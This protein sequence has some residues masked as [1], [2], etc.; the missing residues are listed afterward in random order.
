M[1]WGLCS[2]GN[3]GFEGGGIGFM[4]ESRSGAS[5]TREK[6]VVLYSSWARWL[7]FWV[8]SLASLVFLWQSLF[9]ERLQLQVGRRTKV[10][11]SKI[12]YLI[13]SSGFRVGR[14]PAKIRPKAGF[15]SL[16]GA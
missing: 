6:V 1:S 13:G 9:L 5:R 3:G 7:S 14:L 2:C 10:N 11:S 15:K 8:A 12:V 4:K 16:G